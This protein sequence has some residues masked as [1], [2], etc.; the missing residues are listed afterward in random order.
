MRTERLERNKR[1]DTKHEYV[2]CGVFCEAFFFSFYIFYTNTRHK[3]RRKDMGVSGKADRAWDRDEW[4]DNR[5]ISRARAATG[6]GSS[7]YLRKGRVTTCA[8][9]TNT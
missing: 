6:E 7:D 5:L 8:V 2:A 3:E 1:G 4:R 9:R